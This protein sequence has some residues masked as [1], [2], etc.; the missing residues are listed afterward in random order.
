MTT[1][2]LVEVAQA[3]FGSEQ[4]ELNELAN[5]RRLLTQLELKVRTNPILRD[6]VEAVRENVAAREARLGLTAR[7]TTHHLGPREVEGFAARSF[8]GSNQAVYK[9]DALFHAP[10]NNWGVRKRERYLGTVEQIFED[11]TFYVRD[12]EGKLIPF[13]NINAPIFDLD[14][15]PEFRFRVIKKASC[16]SAF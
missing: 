12:P 13:G 14:D 10:S 6:R 1:M 9:G 11:G 7:Q 4:L 5:A 2:S 8:S 15:A 3:Q 16:L